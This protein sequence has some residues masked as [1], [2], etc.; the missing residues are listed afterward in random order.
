MPDTIYSFLQRRENLEKQEFLVDQTNYQL[1]N[2][3]ELSDFDRVMPATFYADPLMII[4]RF[5]KHRPTVATLISEDAEVPISR[6]QF[7]LNEE[8]LSR[9]KL[10]K[11]Y[12]WKGADMDLLQ[13]L[14]NPH[15][16]PAL[17]TLI[18]NEFFGTV[19]GLVPA[20]YDKSKLLT[21]PVAL[22]GSTTFT[23]PISGVQFALSY[24]DALVA[25][26]MPI[27]LT[28]GARWNQPTTCTPLQNWQDHAEAIYYN[29]TN[30]LGMYPAYVFLNRVNFLRARD[31]NEA[32]IAY[33]RELGNSTSGTPDFSGL[34]IPEPYFEG[35]IA[36]RV[37][38]RG[39]C[40]VVQLDAKISEEQTNGTILDKFLMAVD[41]NTDY[42]FFGW[43]G[44]IERAFTP[45]VESMGAGG[46]IYIVNG[47]KTDDIPHRYW[48]A[49]AANFVP[50]VRDPR[51]I[52]ARK[53]V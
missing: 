23:D 35:M 36:R 48:T 51:M 16:T 46:G 30:P 33:L 22:T 26:H 21:V 32:K 12:A 40:K 14:N 24:A 8:T 49:A 18:E 50:I 6:P 42:Y 1:Q 20:I 25:E 34:T 47:Q 19:A 2:P 13:K 7:A 41:G 17:R 53:V 11:K 38:P 43:D 44:Y 9:A 31:S 39:T 15:T 45:P 37:N 29:S 27:P 28:A 5:T 10:G 4:R 52:A 3:P